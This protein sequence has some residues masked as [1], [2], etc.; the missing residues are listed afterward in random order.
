MLSCLIRFAV[1]LGRNLSEA[2]SRIWI[3]TAAG[4]LFMVTR[5]SLQCRVFFFIWVGQFLLTRERTRGGEEAQA[6]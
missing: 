1:G 5:Y 3:F 6:A 4:S 2:Y